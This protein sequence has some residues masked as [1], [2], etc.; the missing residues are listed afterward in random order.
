M[1]A[2]RRNVLWFSD[3]DPGQQ[4]EVHSVGLDA[5]LLLLLNLGFCRTPVGEGAL[6]HHGTDPP[7]GTRGKWSK[8]VPLLQHHWLKRWF[9]LSQ[10]IWED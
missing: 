2:V 10:R 6:V 9:V 5:P 8:V 1:H 3:L 4:V 7:G